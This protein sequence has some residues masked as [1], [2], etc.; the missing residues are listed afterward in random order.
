[1]ALNDYEQFQKQINHE[2]SRSRGTGG[3][4][5]PSISISASNTPS[6][7]NNSRARQNQGEKFLDPG[8]GAEA[9]NS[10][11][12]SPNFQHQQLDGAGFGGLQPVHQ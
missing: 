7:L 1:V 2:L 10:N 5:N 4:G 3:L 11:F 12:M 6:H 9:P 8:L